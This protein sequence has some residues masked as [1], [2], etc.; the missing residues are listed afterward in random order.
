MLIKKIKHCQIKCRR[1]NLLIGYQ[2]QLRTITR[3]TFYIVKSSEVVIIKE[4]NILKNLIFIKFSKHYKNSKDKSKNFEIESL[5]FSSK[6]RCLQIL[7]N[8]ISN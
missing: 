5:F 4:V 2:Q 8:I 7:K 1:V 6:C 3:N